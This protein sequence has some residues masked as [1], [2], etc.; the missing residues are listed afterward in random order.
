LNKLFAD[1]QRQHANPFRGKPERDVV[2]VD[3]SPLEV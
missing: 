2:G 1:V 3:P